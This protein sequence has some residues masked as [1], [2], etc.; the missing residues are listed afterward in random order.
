ML[1]I[2][3]EQMEAF[4][5]AADTAF[6]RRVVEYLRKNHSEVV[7]QLPKGIFLVKQIPDGTLHEMVQNGIVRARQYDLSWESN[8]MAFVVLMFVA[9]PNFDAYPLMQ[10]VL[11]DAEIPPNFRIDDLWKKISDQTW[12]MIKQNYNPSAWNLKLQENGE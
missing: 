7:V 11:R 12:D 3:P 8:L 10:Q 4:Q 2:R 6:E 1:T 5:R 9:A